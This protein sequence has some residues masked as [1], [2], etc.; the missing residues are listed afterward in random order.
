M[1]ALQLLFNYILHLDHYVNALTSV[2]GPWTYIFLFVIFFC[3][4]GIIFT[5]FL[6]GDSLLF[7]AGTVAAISPDNLNVHLLFILLLTASVL[8]NAVNYF[9][10]KWVGP[11]IFCNESLLFNRKHLDRTHA[12]YERYGAKA[13]V[14]A[15]FM[16]IVRTFAPFV[17]GIGAMS[18]KRFLFFNFI[19]ATLWIG[20]ILYGSY[21]FGN[22]PF[23][24]AHF[25][26]VILTIILLSLLPAIV[27]FSRKKLPTGANSVKLH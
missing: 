19:G 13:I 6:P 1:N 17:A 16:P 18:Y 23:V 7:A 5:A 3:E 20:S 21:F 25:S 15:R 4:T 8:G 9:T 26:A 24:R 27:E 22:I 14:I 10:G 12:F 11:R 2:L